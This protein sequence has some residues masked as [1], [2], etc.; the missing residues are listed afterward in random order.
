MIFGILIRV[1][2]KSSSL[3]SIVVPVYNESS[4]LPGL[5]TSLSSVLSK[6]EYTFEVI[7]VNDGSRDD[8]LQI[9]HEIAAKDSR[10]RILSLSRNFGKEIAT[11]A[12]LHTARGTAI[13]TLDADGQHPVELIPKFIER[14]KLGAKVVI[15]VRTANQREGIVKRL[16][17]KLFYRTINWFASTHIVPKSTDFRLI[18]RVVQQAF[19]QMTERNRIT[20]GLIDWLGYERDYIEYV[21]NARQHGDAGYS[22]RSLVKLAVDSVVSLSVSPL[23]IAAYLG[24]FVL[25]VSVLLFLFMVSDAILRDP[26]NL[27]LTGGAYVLVLMLF[28]IGVLLL[29]QGIIGLYLSHIHSETQNRPLYIVDEQHSLGL[30][31]V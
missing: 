11:T 19:A 5:H 28:L 1:M 6:A 9:L 30:T 13:I 12:G 14:W 25:P 22:F 18:D 7:Y 26:L 20:R 16:G 27:R 21:A 15:G 8:S 29:S 17:S 2:T 31:H 3:I 23:Y 24:A 10:V 4:N